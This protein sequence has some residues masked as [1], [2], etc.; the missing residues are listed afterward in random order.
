MSIDPIYINY[1]QL[2]LGWGLS[3][4][5]NLPLPLKVVRGGT[6][7]P[8]HMPFNSFKVVFRLVDTTPDDVELKLD[9][10]IGG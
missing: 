2:L 6:T 5:P 4:D 10:G 3:V 8:K 9:I 1:H 7:Y